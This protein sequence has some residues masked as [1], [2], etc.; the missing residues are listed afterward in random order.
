MSR[1]NTPSTAVTVADPT[2]AVQMAPL[3]GALRD[4]N[5]HG[6]Q[7]TH[8]QVALLK[9]TVAKGASD[10]ELALFLNQCSRLQLDPFLKQVHLVK[11]WSAD[12]GE[13]MAIQI[14]I[15]GL[16]LQNERTSLF[17][18]IEGPFW[19]G[20]DQQWQEVWLGAD[21]PVAAKVTV[22]RKD[23]TRP[24]SY[25]ALFSE[26]AQTKRGGA[27][28][29]MWASRGTH[30]LGKCAE[31]GARRKAFPAEL[32]GVYIEEELM[33]DAGTGD[34]P[35]AP[36]DPFATV[37]PGPEG[38]FGGNAGKRLDE[39]PASVLVAFDTWVMTDPDRQHRFLSVVADAAKVLNDPDYQE[40]E[41]ARV[42][43]K[44]AKKA[45][46]TPEPPKAAEPPATEP[47]GAPDEDAP[48][49]DAPEEEEERQPPPLPPRKPMHNA[50][51]PAALQD[52]NDDLPFS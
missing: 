23:S 3:G 21:L 1:P 39:C 41:K 11:R 42:A 6:A 46:A 27:L 47:D 7:M 51:L 20:P 14:G 36:H 48:D 16:R 24:I 4:V 50:D 33:R 29:H 17:D 9:N 28:S 22:Y 40:R 15:D 18:G 32:S 52:E 5:V 35:D 45:K 13:T 30:M 44:K 25:V 37:L 26:Y 34:V 31:A 12:A 10:D 2:T 49:E 8:A 38:A 19:C 43:A